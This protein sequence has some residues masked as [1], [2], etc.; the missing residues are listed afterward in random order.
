MVDNNQAEYPPPE[1]LAIDDLLL[2]PL[3]PRLPERM[4]G[5][6]QEELLEFVTEEYDVLAVARSIALHGYFPS[7][8]VIVLR[9]EGVL[10][11]VEGNRR[12]A[13]IKLASDEMLRAE[14]DL[15]DEDDWRQISNSQEIPTYI[16]AIVVEDRASIAPIVGYRH[17]S[18]IEPWDPWAKARFIGGLIEEAEEDADFSVLADEVGEPTANIRANYRNLMIVQRARALGLETTR[19]EN[20]FGVFTRS[21]NSPS[22][23]DHIGTP[24]HTDVE[25]DSVIIPDEK[26][27]ELAELIGWLFGIDDLPAVIGESRDITRL[28]TVVASEEGL[29]VLRESRDLEEAHIAA[30]GLKERLM[31]RLARARG[32]LEKAIQDLPD[33]VEDDEVIELLN[34]C[35]EALAQ[36]TEILNPN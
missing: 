32:N 34:G 25:I 7:E 9:G 16:P 33:Y 21:M 15:S 1:D 35:E 3:N 8:P 29:R 26:R 10:T 28:G 22:L 31:R 19:V 2:D 17:I 13:A 20:K 27:E 24:S 36:L 6:P 18:G 4:R 14:L 23:R 11:V 30:G 12:L 5:A